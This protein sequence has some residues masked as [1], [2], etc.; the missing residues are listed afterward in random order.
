[1]IKSFIQSLLGIRK[2]T[3]FPDVFESF[4]IGNRILT[5]KGQNR[6]NS[7]QILKL[8]RITISNRIRRCRVSAAT[9]QLCPLDLTP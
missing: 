7:I 4:Y 2:S 6:E 5:C 3:V 8:I 9:Q 1:M